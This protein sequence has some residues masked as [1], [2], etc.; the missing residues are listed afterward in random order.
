MNTF[1]YRMPNKVSMYSCQQ[2]SSSH[3]LTDDRQYLCR[4]WQIHH[5]TRRVSWRER[6]LDCL[7]MESARWVHPT[8]HQPVRC[9]C[10]PHR[11]GEF[12]L[13]RGGGG[14]QCV[15]FTISRP[16]VRWPRSLS[17]ISIASFPLSHRTMRG[18]WMP[19]GRVQASGVRGVGAAVVSLG[20]T[21]LFSLSSQAKTH[22]YCIQAP[23][24]LRLM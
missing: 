2:V 3:S 7:K 5:V 6:K 18:K 9:Q 15:C 19:P 21:S 22:G 23:L 4:D 14:E 17:S 24:R 1:A 12:S 20:I 8:R 10:T 11:L 13:V 16:C